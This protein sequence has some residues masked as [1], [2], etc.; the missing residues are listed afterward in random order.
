[1]P[2]I[3]ADILARKVVEHR[4]RGYKKIVQTFGEEGI[5]QDGSGNIDQKKKKLVFGDE[6]SDGC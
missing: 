1:M 6:E 4:T 5:L 2:V 3:D